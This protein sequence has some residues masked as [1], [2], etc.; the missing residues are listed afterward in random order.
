MKQEA[1]IVRVKS[2]EAEAKLYPYK[3]RYYIAC[4][5]SSVTIS[6]LNGKNPY[7]TGKTKQERLLYPFGRYKS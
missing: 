1:L 7:S 5:Q 4:A 6:D 3:H 2:I